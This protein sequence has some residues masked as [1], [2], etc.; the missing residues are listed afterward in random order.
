MSEIQS[1]GL[2]CAS[3]VI[4]DPCAMEVEIIST[5]SECWCLEFATVQC[6]IFR[7]D[8]GLTWEELF[9][10]SFSLLA[11]TIRSFACGMIVLTRL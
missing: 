3:C 8:P 9:N 6:L 4:K 1:L 2:L 11:C 10:A 7:L 5:L